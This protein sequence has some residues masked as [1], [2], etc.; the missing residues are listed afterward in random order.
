MRRAVFLDRDGV[1]N[2]VQVREGRPYPPDTASE[3]QIPADAAPALE[4]LRTAG[5][6]LIVVTNQPD[7]A[8]GKQ[9]REGVEAIHQILRSALPVDDFFVC[10]HDDSDACD[11]RKPLPGL[12]TAAA[13]RYDIDL[14]ASYLIGDRWRDIDAGAA[15][16]CT[17]ILIDYGYRERAPQHTADIR[18]RSLRE[19]VQWILARGE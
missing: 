9:T 16:G 8:R 5:F 13:A 17:T 11:C 6:L 14:G 18:V 2:Q 4:S 3:V 19:G 12:L 7:V 1:L 10:Y 15:A